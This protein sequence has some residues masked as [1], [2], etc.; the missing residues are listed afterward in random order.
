MEDQPQGTLQNVLEQESLKWVFVGGRG[1]VGKTTCWKNYMQFYPL[2]PSRFC[3]LFRSHL[4]GPCSQSQRCLLFNYASRKP[5]LWL[6]VYPMYMQQFG[7][8]LCS[9]NPGAI[10]GIDEAMNFAEMLKEI[11]VY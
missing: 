9:L 6:M 1:G 10:P 2:Y 7:S 5:L 4:N 3:S 8:I 11:I